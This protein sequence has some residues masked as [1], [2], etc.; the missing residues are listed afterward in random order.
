[1]EE[2][3]KEITIERL[4]TTGNANETTNPLL[5]LK[6]KYHRNSI[7]NQSA[8]GT[9]SKLNRAKTVDAQKLNK[10]KDELEYA[11]NWRRAFSKVF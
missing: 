4:D 8:R 10:V 9:A 2:D 6:N 11:T 3:E 5:G 7:S 1:L